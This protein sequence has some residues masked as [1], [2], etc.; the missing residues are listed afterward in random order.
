MSDFY[1]EADEKSFSN[2]EIPLPPLQSGFIIQFC[3]KPVH[4]NVS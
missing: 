4:T 2:F 1:L 3:I